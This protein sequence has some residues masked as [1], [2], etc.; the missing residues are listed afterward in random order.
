VPEGIALDED[1]QRLAELGYKQ[2]LNR[3]W[4][5]FSNFAISFSII[6][7]L[8]GCFTTYGQ[9]WINGGPVAI[10]IGWPVISVFILLVAFCAVTNSAAL[11][12]HLDVNKQVR[13]P[14]EWECSGCVS[15]MNQ[16]LD[17]LINIIANV[18]V[19]GGCSA[20]CGY[21]NQNWEIEICN[22][23]CDVVGIMEFANLVNDADP[24]PLWICIETDMCPYND[25]SKGVMKS[26]TVSPTKAP[27]GT[28]FTIT[29]VYQITNI[30]G[31]GEVVVEV[32]PSDGSFPLD[33]GELIVAQPPGMYK[34]VG[35]L[36][37]Q[38]TED[39]PF[40][41]GSYGVVAAVCEGSC[42]GTHSHTFT[43]C[44]GQSSFH[45]TQ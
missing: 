34:V 4:S 18:G 27:Q 31:V 9:A 33:M 37:T 39:D 28:T 20:V 8:A 17:Q 10:S 13:A 19:L 16:A 2:E 25:Y 6:S 12:Q 30:T 3:S 11:V 7:I 43:I 38:P 26:I 40:N 44:Q 42:G 5:G 1:E 15:F 41:P 29:V 14:Q 22:V 23:V 35:Q 45:I 24:D 32:D 21:L 36:Q